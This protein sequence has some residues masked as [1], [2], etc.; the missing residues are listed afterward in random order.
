MSA[1]FSAPGFAVLCLGLLYFRDEFGKRVIEFT[2]EHAVG[3]FLVID[4]GHQ[5]S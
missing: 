3:R 2:A 4:A 5:G 1:S